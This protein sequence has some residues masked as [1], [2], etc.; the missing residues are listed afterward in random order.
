MPPMFS[1]HSW[2]PVGRV[3]DV[4]LITARTHG[5]DDSN[6]QWS[7]LQR[8]VIING[9]HIH[10]CFASTTKKHSLLDNPFFDQNQKLTGGTCVDEAKSSTSYHSFYNFGNNLRKFLEAFLFFRYPSAD[11]NNDGRLRL[12]FGDA[13]SS[14]DFVNR[15]TNEHSHLE[16]FVDRG[17]VPIDCAEI[18]RMASFVLEAMRQKDPVQYEHFLKSV[19]AV[20]PPPPTCCAGVVVYQCWP[21]IP[22]RAVNSHLRYATEL[23][24]NSALPPILIN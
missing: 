19:G 15:L 23:C 21:T 6:A 10:R 20:D 22:L 13:D 1:K 14:M 12:F 9:N 24:H 8:R 18:S 2:R 5:L 11:V 17:M 4:K 16:E 7:V 3:L